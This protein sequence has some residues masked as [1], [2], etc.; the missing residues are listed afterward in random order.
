MMIYDKVGR[1]GLIQCLNIVFLTER[2]VS[3]SPTHTHTYTQ[4]RAIAFMA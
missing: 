2:N 4:A 1:L 3:A